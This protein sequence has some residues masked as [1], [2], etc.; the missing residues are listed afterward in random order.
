MID[1]SVYSRCRVYIGLHTVPSEPQ[2][3]RGRMYVEAI[4]TWLQVFCV[5]ERYDF[6]SNL[7][8]AAAT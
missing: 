7:K 6:L 2:H 5:W 8:T 1:R 4:D 3:R